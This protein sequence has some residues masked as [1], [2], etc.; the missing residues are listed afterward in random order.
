MPPVWA[1]TTCFISLF[2]TDVL[3]SDPCMG[4][5]CIHSQSFPFSVFSLLVLACVLVRDDM[6]RSDIIVF[7][8]TSF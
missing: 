7:V 4:I 1:L 2:S 5:M 6:T 8:M 3:E